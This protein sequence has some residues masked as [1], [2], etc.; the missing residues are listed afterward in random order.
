MYGL[1]PSLINLNYHGIQSSI[2]SE[3]GEIYRREGQRN[4]R[5]SF[6]SICTN[7]FPSKSTARKVQIRYTHCIVCHCAIDLHAVLVGTRMHACMYHCTPCII[8]FSRQQCRTGQ[9]HCNQQAAASQNGR[10][11]SAAGYINPCP[12]SGPNHTQ[13]HQH[14]AI[15]NRAS[16]P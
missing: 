1:V 13:T 2:Y 10:K 15:A 5:G 16:S 3:S 4:K 9:H 8:L 6:I 14:S 7:D 11:G 12:C